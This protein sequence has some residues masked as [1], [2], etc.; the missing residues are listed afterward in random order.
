[1]GA[2]AIPNADGTFTIVHGGGA[3]TSTIYDAVHNTMNNGPT[4]TTA[5]NC[6]FWSIPLQNDTYK[7]F[8]GVA[9]GS[10]GS[11]TSMNYNPSTKTFVAGTVLTGAHGCGSFVF[12]RADGYWIALPPPVALAV[13]HPT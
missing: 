4:L 9:S 12:Q 13:P 5:A 7:T 6:G 10:I 2:S 1:M 8:V 11:T 3:T